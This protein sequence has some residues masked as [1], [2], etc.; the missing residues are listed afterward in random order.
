M[1]R[2]D[3]RN[4]NVSPDR[5][6][7]RAGDH[8]PDTVYRRRIEVLAGRLDKLRKY[9]TSLGISKL[10]L[11]LVGGLSLFRIF[12]ANPEIPWA[13]F[14]PA[15]ILFVTGI[16]IHES[17]IRKSGHLKALRTIN[18]NELKFLGHEFPA[19]AD[20]GSEFQNPDHA[21]SSDLDIFGGKSLFHYVNRAVTAVGRRCLSD[22]LQAPAAPEEIERRQ[23]AVQELS[24]K[25]DF[26]QNIASFGMFI[27]DSS[28]QLDS[29]YKALDEPFLLYGK[30]WPRIFLLA[31]PIL[32][33][34]AAVLIFFKVS[35]VFLLV[36][37]VSQSVAN[38]KFSNRV[39]RIYTLTSRSG[40]ILRAYS[41]IIGE[42]EAERFDDDK[43]ARLKDQLSGSRIHASE[44]IRQFSKLLEW[45]DARNGMLHVIFNNIF[46]WDLNCV[47]RIEKW[48]AHTAAHIPQWFGAIGEFEALSGFAALHFNNPRWALPEV[49]AGSFRLQAQTLGHPLIPEKDRIGS[50]FELG[51]ND[52]ADA[53]GTLAIVTG[54]NMAGKSTFLR[55]V[56]VNTILALAGGPVCAESL[57]ITPVKLITSMKTSDS[58][59]KHLSLFYAELQRLKTVLDGI[60]G[61]EPVFF[62]I[63]EML[64]GTNALDRQKGSL[65]LLRQ[66]LRNG[67]NGIVATHD[68]E[69]T[70]L[71]NREEWEKAKSPY[72]EGV[73]IAN[74]HFDG[75]VENDKLLFD[76][77]LKQGVCRSH[78]ALVLMKKMGIDLD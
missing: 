30:K 45:F 47:Y 22:W 35:A 20:P 48:R 53:A 9:G 26:R 21:F 17:V 28:R 34:G 60:L 15:M 54:P 27:D 72:P 51:T 42:I 40:R 57:S 29:L 70:K 37:T 46:F 23:R 1:L 61:G 67:A 66:L 8:S 31:W 7:R 32:T 38:R 4:E 56:G 41:R 25:I 73:R 59:D 74:Y 52:K 36:M 5:P 44:S 62:L 58:L 13:V 65:A 75:Y 68:L 49:A 16:V 63:D 69:L 39:K 33:V 12:T 2:L 43:L 50:S 64:K 18:E 11:L 24:Q 76:Y 78:N 71:E 19:A 3:H 55:S 77:R 10:A 14:G 6:G